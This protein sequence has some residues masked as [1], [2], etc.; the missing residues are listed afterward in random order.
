MPS[1]NRPGKLE[2]HPAI[3]LLHRIEDGILISLLLIMIIMAV[4]QITLRNLF[5]SGILWGDAFVRVTVL[6]IGL[7]GAM[8]ASRN[9]HHISIDIVSKFLPDRLKN[10]C[11]LL[12]QLFTAAI[13]GIMTYYSTTFVLLE[14]EDGI[15]AFASVPV[16]LCEAII[17]AAFFVMA[18]RYII[19]LFQTAGALLRRVSP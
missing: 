14:K 5:D 12:T 8:I 2:P 15:H 7:I 4:L 18:L 6:W 9:N 19:L 17:P 16:W 1:E 3:K 11:R 10:I 13:C